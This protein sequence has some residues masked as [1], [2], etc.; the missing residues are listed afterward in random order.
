ML[1]GTQ[2][3]IERLITRQNSFYF[4]PDKRF[5]FYHPFLE[6]KNEVLLWLSNKKCIWFPITFS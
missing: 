3:P 1:K 6:T 2:K 4:I 5:V